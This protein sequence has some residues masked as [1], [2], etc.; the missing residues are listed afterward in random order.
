MLPEQELG[1]ASRGAVD[2]L[3]T[4][5]LK[6]LATVGAGERFTLQVKGNYGWSLRLLVLGRDAELGAAVGAEGCVVGELGPAITTVFHVQ[7][8]LM[9]QDKKNPAKN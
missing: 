8:G 5:L 6:L 2:A 4:G 1:G 7:S 9:A 3:A